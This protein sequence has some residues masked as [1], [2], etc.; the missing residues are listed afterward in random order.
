MTD[1]EGLN[2]GIVLPN[3]VVEGDSEELVEYGVAAEEAGWH[4]VLLAD[5]LMFPPVG[6]E[7][8]LDS[9]GYSD[10][11]DPWVTAAGIAARTEE[12]R[13]VSWIT[14]VPRR[15]PWQLARNLATLDRLSDGRVILG[16]GLGTPSDYTRFGESWEPKQLGKKYDEALDIIKGLWSGEPFSY[17][18]DFFAIDHAVLKPTPVQEP[19][20][21]VIIGGIWPNKK[22]FHRGARWDG[23]VP[24]YRG[25]GVVPQDGATYAPPRHDDVTHDEEVQNMVEYYNSIVDEPGELFLPADPPD[26]GPDWISQ[27]KKLGATWVY[28]RPKR[29]TGEWHLDEEYIRDGPPT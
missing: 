15:Q 7:E 29:E 26:G 5:H 17:D 20:I 24:H 21:P 12:I 10:F 18:G 1:S 9:S 27:C 16:A 14:P 11:P 2:Y 8:K 28:F 19:R 6:P 22:P 25:D 4:G 23:M 13:L 3:W